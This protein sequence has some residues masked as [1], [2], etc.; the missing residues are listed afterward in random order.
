MYGS[1]GEPAG[2]PECSRAISTELC[3]SEFEVVV[4]RPLKMRC[5]RELPGKAVSWISLG[6]DFLHIHFNFSVH[7]HSCFS[8]VFMYRC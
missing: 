7:M 4:G 2:R 1:S 3:G 5:G 8:N 6:V